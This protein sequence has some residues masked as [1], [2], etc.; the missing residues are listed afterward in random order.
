MLRRYLFIISCIAIIF[1]TLI[2]I[3]I[4]NFISID[5]GTF[6][7][8][9]GLIGTIT[10]LTFKAPLGNNGTIPL[11]SA[12]QKGRVNSTS[13]NPSQTKT[14]TV[15]SIQQGQVNLSGSPPELYP[16]QS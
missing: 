12:L 8:S 1:G 10:Q 4:H 3:L 2:Q 15:G 13:S 5:I 11:D 7:N 9:L 16:R 14:S 6:F